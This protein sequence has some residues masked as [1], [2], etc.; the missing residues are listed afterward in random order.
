MEDIFKLINQV[1]AAS[2]NKKTIFYVH[3]YEK[4]CYYKLYGDS[5]EYVQL[6]KKVNFK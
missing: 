1:K 5:V 2:D 4:D 3:Q 6:P